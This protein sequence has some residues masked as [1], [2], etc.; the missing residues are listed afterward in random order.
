MALAR[1]GGHHPRRHLLDA[2]EFQHASGEHEAVAGGEPRDERLLDVAQPV[3]IAELHADAGVGHDGAD[4]RAMPARDGGIR[5]ARDAVVADH[6]AA[7]L[8]IRVEA[9]AAVDDEV[10]RPLPLRVRQLR[11]GVRAAQ[12]PRSS[13]AGHEAAAQRARD[14]VLDQRVERRVQRRARFELALLRGVA[15][16]GGLDQFQRL[17]RHDRHLRD[18]ARLVAAAAGA[19]QQPRDALGRA[20]LQHLVDRREVHA[21][22]EARRADDG[23]QLVEA[24]AFLDPVAHVAL[25]RTVMQAQCVRPNRDAPRGSPG[26]RSRWRSGHCRTPASSARRRWRE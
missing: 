9:G 5:H 15:R 14:Q 18:R 4:R 7:V 16:G 1:L 3:A 24:Q 21:Q 20:D 25:Q 13:S 2:H 10:Q 26:T 11:V 17:R 6:D 12:A 22:I 8:R 23:L 19:L